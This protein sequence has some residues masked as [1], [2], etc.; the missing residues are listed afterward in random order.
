MLQPHLVP[1]A[2]GISSTL[3]INQLVG[4]LRDNGR[5][6]FHMGFGEAPFPVHPRLAEA[7]RHNVAEKSYLPVAGLPELREAVAQHYASLT[8]I[9]TNTFDVIVG[10]G[11]KSLLFALQMSIPGDV[12]LPVPSWVSYAPQCSLLN[13]QLIPVELDLESTG[14][15]IDSL[16]LKNAI[17]EARAAGLTPKKLLLNYPSNP[18]GLT[19]TEEALAC[20]AAVC[21]EENIVL[22]ADEIY[23]RL[24]YDHQYRTA[25]HHLPESTV[26]TAGLS[27][28]L[29]LGGWRL[30]ITLIP[31]ALPGVFDEMCRVAS[32]LWSSVA[33]PIQYAAIEAYQ[34]HPDIETFIRDCTDIHACVNRYIAH[35]LR[36][37][38]A[39]CP[40]PQGG[41]YTWP[42]FSELLG[43]TCE[44]SDD[45]MQRLLSDQGVATLAGAAFGEAPSTLKLRL[46]GC[47]YDGG[48]ALALW[49]ALKANTEAFIHAAAPNVIAALDAIECFVNTNARPHARLTPVSMNA[50]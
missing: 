32:E 10:P 41:F 8:G 13:Q 7:L 36:A 42:D 4:Q 11:S 6:V 40:T 20:I 44:T 39:D 18:T 5:R 22:I 30:G 37:M 38:G 2:D 1:P 31:K 16:A 26:V 34:G 14:L 27:K 48:A 21:R 45:L 50:S 17:R 19:I 15:S 33:S 12:L 46:A 47:D 24:S 49:P 25:A 3:A 43:H 29:S 9:D 28:H 35:R 23:G